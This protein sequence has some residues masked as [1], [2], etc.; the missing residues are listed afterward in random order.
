VRK[1]HGA[2]GVPDYSKSKK[3]VTA[4]AP[5]CKPG[6]KAT[7]KVNY[8]DVALADLRPPMFTLHVVCKGRSSV[9][10]ECVCAA[11]GGKTIRTVRPSK[12]SSDILLK[13]YMK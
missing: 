1:H 7:P 4:A 11:T 2:E 5:V 6:K 12:V 9:T 8:D 3:P 13:N 10:I